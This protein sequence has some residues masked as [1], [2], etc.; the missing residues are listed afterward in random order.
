MAAGLAAV[1]L[2]PYLLPY[3]HVYH[4]QGMTRSIGDAT[5][6][7]ATWQNYLSTPSRLHSALM[8]DEWSS[9]APAL[10]P[11]FTGLA[12]V[13]LAIW[14]GK[15]KDA[16]VR[17]CLAIGVAGVLLSFGGRLPGYALLYN[18]LP[19]LHSIR[20][21]ARFGYLGIVAV[22]AV[23]GFGV[24]EL[25]RLVPR[26]AWKP[27]AVSLALLVTVEPLAAPLG[28]ARFEGIPRIYDRLLSDQRALVVELP[29][30]NPQTVSLN[31]AYLL[32]STRNW[33]P[34]V[35]G[36]SGFVPLSYE[37]HFEQLG[38]FPDRNA[39]DALVRLGVT[40]VFVHLEAFGGAQLGDQLDR[41]PPLRRAATEGSI[42]LYVIDRPST[43]P[44]VAP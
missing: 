27:V 5:F 11:G 8:G 15:A 35:N 41:T 36:Y 40:H 9:F 24:V 26:A 32:N 18:T 31:A 33:R 10:F 22:S 4:D 29:F 1:A 6:F 39:I 23:A 34:L 28:F 17:M 44:R 38:G 19:L 13:A 7:A 25:R 20:M 42:A 30:P 16:R 3:W 37:Q 12:L 2:A 14:R 43:E 21:T